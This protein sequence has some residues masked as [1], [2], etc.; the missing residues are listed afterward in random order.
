MRFSAQ[1]AFAQEEIKIRVGSGGLLEGYYSIGLKLCCY[2]SRV[3]NGILYEVVMPNKV[4]LEN[5]WLLQRGKIN[6]AFILSELAID[7][8]K[9]KEYFVTT[10]AFK[11]TPQVLNLRSKIFTVIVKDDNILVFSDL[12]GKKIAN[13]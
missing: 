7:S 8:F 9:G 13:G 1:S 12:D 2:I 4:S 6:F 5:L 10:E 11:N 3:N